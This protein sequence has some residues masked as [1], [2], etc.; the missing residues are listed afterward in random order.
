M[1]SHKRMKLRILRGDI[2]EIQSIVKRARIKK[3]SVKGFL[4]GKEKKRTDDNQRPAKIAKDEKPNIVGLP[5]NGL[6]NSLVKLQGA[7]LCGNLRQRHPRATSVVKSESE[8]GRQ[9]PCP[10][11]MDDNRA[12]D[13]KPNNPETTWK[14]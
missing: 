4:K 3:M 14:R 6:G 13:G 2:G 1:K 11:G 5:E 7:S 10:S 9:R 12:K 8:S